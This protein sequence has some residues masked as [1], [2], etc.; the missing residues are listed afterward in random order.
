MDMWS[1]P[2]YR[3]P[4][5]QGLGQMVQPWCFMSERVTAHNVLPQLSGHGLEFICENS[6]DYFPYSCGTLVELQTAAQ[7]VALAHR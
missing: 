6:F 7:C 4:P 5:P 3:R 2:K 1:A